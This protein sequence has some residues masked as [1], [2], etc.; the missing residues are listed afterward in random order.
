MESEMMALATSSE[1]A[2]WLRCLL[3]EITLWV[4]PL[5]VMLVHCDSIATI[6]KIENHYYNGKR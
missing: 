2:S 4:K 6:A 5:P 3:A 1:E